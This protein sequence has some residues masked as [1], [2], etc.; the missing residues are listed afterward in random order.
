MLPFRSLLI[1]AATGSLFGQTFEK[2]VQPVLGKTC[3]PCHNEQLESGGLNIAAFTKVSSLTADRPG[4]DRILDKLRAG[5][6]PPKGVPRPAG[7]DAA[8]EYLDGEFAKADRNSKPDPGR[9]TAR[10]LNRV[11]YSNTIRDLLA[12]DFRAEKSFPTDDLGNGFDNIGDVLTVSP[13]LM[14]KYLSASGSVARR[15]IGADP[16]PK[17]PLEIQLHMKDRKVRR[18]DASSIEGT[19]HIEFDGEYTIRIGLPGER[20]K[21]AKAVQLGFWM[22]GK[23]LNT[24][25]AETK[26]SGLVYFN[27]Y[28]DETMRLYIPEGDHVFRAGFIGDDFVKTLTPKELYDSKKNKYLDSITF[29]GPYPSSIE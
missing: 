22:D 5:E 23:L 25:S 17:K 10:R 1:I 13:V 11:E 19:T 29:V 9:V 3:T 2:T 14:E 21:D 8:I 18:V 6:M 24:I 27:P 16:L 15:A 20:G 26:P 28:S 12:V 7:L 4:W